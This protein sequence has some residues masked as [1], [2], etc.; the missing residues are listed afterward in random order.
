MGLCRVEVA[1]GLGFYRRTYLN[2]LILALSS[3]YGRCTLILCAGTLDPRM[4]WC[5]ACTKVITIL[6]LTYPHVLE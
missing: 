3:H 4:H 2:R 5:V 6:L 1:L